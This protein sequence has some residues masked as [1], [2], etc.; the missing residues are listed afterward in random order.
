MICF[1]LQATFLS[2][3]IRLC[4]KAV[5]DVLCTF[6]RHTVQ[7]T[8]DG[9]SQHVQTD[10]VI[11]SLIFQTSLLTLSPVDHSPSIHPQMFVKGTGRATIK[12]DNIWQSLLSQLCLGM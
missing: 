6:M 9:Q 3:S 12:A 1:S 8:R 7:A 5:G 11:P 2:I 4:S 10:I